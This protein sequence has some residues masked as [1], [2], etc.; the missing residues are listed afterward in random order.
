MLQTSVAQ[1]INPSEFIPLP[2]SI[3]LRVGFWDLGFDIDMSIIL[4]FWHAIF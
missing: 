3:I 1:E 2:L 4:D